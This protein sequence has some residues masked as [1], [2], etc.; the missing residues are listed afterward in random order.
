MFNIHRTTLGQY[1]KKAKIH[2]RK[3]YN[4]NEHFFDKI[5][6][7]E[8]AYI[9]GFF[10]ADGCIK[11][12]KGDIKIALKKEDSYILKKMQSIMGN[13]RPLRDITVV[14]SFGIHDATEMNISSV[15]MYEALQR[16]GFTSHKSMNEFLPNIPIVYT[17]DLLRGIFDGD[18]WFSSGKNYV[19]L[20]FGMGLSILNKIRDIFI[21]IGVKDTYKVKPYGNIYR[22]RI[23]SRESIEKIYSYLYEGATMFLIRKHDK[24]KRFAAQGK[25][26]T[27]CLE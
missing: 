9:L 23:T 19:E 26:L 13:E 2:I 5:D 15:I 3:K 22:Y 21:S 14:N 25:D 16:L 20:G 6:S 17:K 4:I 7:A 8:K 24:I 11:S 18:G 10:I 27:E 1:L 12:K